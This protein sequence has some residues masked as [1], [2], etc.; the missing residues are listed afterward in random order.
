M[1]IE[2]SPLYL[3]AFK[4]VYEDNDLLYFS[5]SFKDK[6][7]NVVHVN[8]HSDDSYTVETV[9]EVES[10]LIKHIINLFEADKSLITIPIKNDSSSKSIFETY[11]IK[12]WNK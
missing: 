4:A 5:Y 6:F 3:I 11:Q 7:N 9:L 12:E 2:Q 8:M 1:K 10:D